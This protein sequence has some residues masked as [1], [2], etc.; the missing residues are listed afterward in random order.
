[1]LNETAAAAIVM[2][3]IPDANIARVDRAERD[4]EIIFTVHCVH[5]HTYERIDV[6]LEQFHHTAH[7]LVRV[8]P[9]FSESLT[10]EQLEE[11]FSLDL[12]DD[13]MRHCY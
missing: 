6:W 3:H 8:E 2:R 9:R 1:M 13:S 11:G 7:W 12:S 5:G 10:D 4:G